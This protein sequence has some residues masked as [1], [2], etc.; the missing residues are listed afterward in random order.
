MSATVLTTELHWER[1]RY[2]HYESHVSSQEQ[3]S[4]VRTT[5]TT[6]ATQSR[7]DTDARYDAPRSASIDD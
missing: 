1:E 3:L 5:T 2:N 7:L 4:V 6:T